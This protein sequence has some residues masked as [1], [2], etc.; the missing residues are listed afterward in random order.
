MT[1]LGRKGLQVLTEVINE[2]INEDYEIAFVLPSSRS[3]IKH[4]DST[5]ELQ[6][7]N[8]K[9]CLESVNKWNWNMEALVQTNISSNATAYGKSN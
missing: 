5:M 2:A 6:K 8:H 1:N 9:V 4:N 7:F 3:E